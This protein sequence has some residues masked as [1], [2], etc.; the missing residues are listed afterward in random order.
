MKCS[1]L[2]TAVPMVFVAAAALAQAPGE[3]AAD[4]T[5]VD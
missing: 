1:Y 3:A 5:L 2:L 4:F